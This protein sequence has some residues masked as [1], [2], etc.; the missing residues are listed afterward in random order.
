M[1][2]YQ[3][4][5]AYMVG[6]TTY[7]QATTVQYVRA[8]LN[9]A[10]R[11]DKCK[12]HDNKF[13]EC[14]N[15]QTGRVR[16][17]LTNMINNIKRC[18]QRRAIL[19]GVPVQQKCVPLWLEDMRDICR[20]Y[21]RKGGSDSAYRK[22]V[23]GLTYL[24]VGRASDVATLSWD[25][26]SYVRGLNACAFIIHEEKT[27]HTK[28]LLLLPGTGD[29]GDGSSATPGSGYLDP[30]KLLADAYAHKIFFGNLAPDDER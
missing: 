2:P 4:F 30:Y 27:G 24:S 15:S 10:S 22:V 5:S 7:T 18:H 1:E 26:F 14:L 16:S 29:D 25:T 20:A 13:F 28:F 9:M 12:T 17:W 19:T 6:S 3:Q 8:L 11:M 21:S 23:L